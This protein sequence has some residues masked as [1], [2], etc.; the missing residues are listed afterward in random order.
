MRKVLLY[1]E[2]NVAIDLDSVTEN[3]NQL[4][5]TMRFMVG[6]SSFALKDDVVKCPG[7]YRTI[8]HQIRDETRRA[9]LGVLATNKP[10][11]NN[12]FYEGEDNLCIVSFSGWSH[13][14]PLSRNN[15]LV[16]FLASFVS[17]E[18]DDAFRHNDTTGCIYDF[19]WDKRGV[20]AGMRFGYVCPECLGRIH[21][22]G[23]DREKRTLLSDLQALLDEVS[24]AAKRGMDI[25]VRWSQCRVRAPTSPSDLTRFDVFLCHNNDDKPAVKKIAQALMDQGIH[26]WLDEQ[27][28]CPG[29]RW[30]KTLE[31]QMGA[32]GSAAMFVGQKGIGPWQ[33][34]EIESYIREFVR[35]GCRVI[36]VILQDAP[37]TPELPVFLANYMW[38]DFR[39]EHPNPLDQLI[40][41]ITGRRP[42][43]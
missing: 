19:L 29:T 32:I 2:D 8:S 23:L 28:I 10:Y 5:T 42:S 36:P 21:A 17:F 12:Y 4:C 34:M 25:V 1:K 27:Q 13:L 43:Q 39:K 15:G 16:Y 30:Q 11:D 40:W 18:I 9:Y 26:P 38:V 41:G 24:A 7:T 31:A 6:E 14:T 37:H 22:A 33:D 3:L 20:D 35:R